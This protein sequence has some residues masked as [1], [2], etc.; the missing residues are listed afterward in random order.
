MVRSGS[1]VYYI[2]ASSAQRVSRWWNK[3]LKGRDEET[4][5][6]LTTTVGKHVY[7]IA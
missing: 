4:R 2:V 5:D 6:L 7:S 1:R 3:G